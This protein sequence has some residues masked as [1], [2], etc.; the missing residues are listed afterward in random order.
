MKNTRYI[1]LTLLTVSFLV[2]ACGNK[3]NQKN[4][5]AHL[6]RIIKVRN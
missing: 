3:E 1:I 5:D 2:T 6:Q 4:E